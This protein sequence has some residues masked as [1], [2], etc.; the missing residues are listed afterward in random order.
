MS[1]VWQTILSGVLLLVSLSA[2]AYIPRQSFGLLLGVFAFSFAAYIYLIK[3]T[4]N[5]PLMAGVGLLVLSRLLFFF[6]LPLLSEDFYRFIWDGMLLN[7]GFGAVG[8]IPSQVDLTLLQN[9]E[10]AEGLFQSMNSPDYPSIYPPLHQLLG[11]AAYFVGSDSLLANVNVLRAFFLIAEVSLL[12]YVSQRAQPLLKC[13]WVYLFNPL[14]VVEGIGNVHI[15][16]FL[17]PLLGIG[18]IAMTR[19]QTIVSA[20]GWASSVLVKL[21]P[22]ILAP[23]IFFKLKWPQRLLFAGVS[24]VCLL[25]SFLVFNPLDL[26]ASFSDGMGIYYGIF[27]FN[28]S[29]YYLLRGLL[30]PIF[31]YNP[32]GVLAP[33]L[34]VFTMLSIVLLAYFKR[35]AP[36]F[37]LALVT[38][39]IYLLTSAIVH[40]WYLLPVVFLAAFAERRY[41]LIW[42]FA[43]MLSYSHYLDPLG[44]KWVFIF[45]EYGGLAIA[46]W[47]EG[48]RGKWLQ[49]H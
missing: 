49:A 46:I 40:P 10:F 37:E 17:V 9:P 1:K 21:V 22:L 7:E 47:L 35:K 43:A 20:L 2:L 11:G 44:P 14:V 27:E 42:S 29:I 19:R 18:L 25:L 23:L 31:G 33:A 26:A 4:S 16:A 6:E 5:L 36:L 45:L 3:F 8:N 32:I 15:E 48:R 28:A 12:V 24:L 30:T 41:I 38:Y 39:L 34:A 13:V